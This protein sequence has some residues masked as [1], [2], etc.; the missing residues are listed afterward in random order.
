MSCTHRC[1]SCRSC[2]CAITAFYAETEGVMPMVT[3]C[4]LKAPPDPERVPLPPIPTPGDATD[5]ALHLARW[6]ALTAALV[7]TVAATAGFFNR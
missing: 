3:G 7:F 1:N 2:T 6:L 4:S 5:K